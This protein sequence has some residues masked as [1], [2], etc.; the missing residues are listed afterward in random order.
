MPS[1]P[2]ILMSSSARSHF[3][4]ARRSQ[5][6]AGVFRGADV[7]AFFAEPFAQRIAHA[8]LIIHNQQT[9]FGSVTLL[10]LMQLLRAACVASR[11]SGLCRYI[12]SRRPALLRAPAV[13]GG[14]PPAE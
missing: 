10:I 7:V 4:S 11:G 9:A 8:Q 14:H 12:V 6:V 1:V 2:R 5:R 3:C 13:E